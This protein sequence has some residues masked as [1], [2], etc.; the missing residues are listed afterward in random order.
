MSN[1]CGEH[2]DHNVEIGRLNRAL[3][4]VDGVKKMIQERRYCVDILIQLK[5]VRA[6]L[7]SIEAN[8][9]E[10]HMQ[11]CL[12]DACVDGDK[13]QLA[14]KIAEVVKLLKSY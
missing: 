6:A 7:R 11:Q 8:I 3:G 14:E 12:E 1:C 9:L 10:R 5:A 2:P 13:E 4:Q